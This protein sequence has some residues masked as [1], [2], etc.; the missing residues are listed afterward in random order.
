ME[1]WEYDN[2]VL[3]NDG[4]LRLRLNERADAGWDLVALTPYKTV[5][6]VWSWN[7]NTLQYLAVYKRR[8]Q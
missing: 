4:D 5:R 6:S 2:E 8:K 3:Y 7:V 1:N